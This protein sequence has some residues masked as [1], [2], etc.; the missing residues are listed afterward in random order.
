[1]IPSVQ[2]TLPDIPPLPVEELV[3]GERQ[4]VDEMIRTLEKQVAGD[5][6]V[7]G[8]AVR[9]AHPK[10]HGL[11]NATFI[12]DETCPV[13]LRHGLFC[14]PRAFPA[15]IRYSN[16][17]PTP[18]HDLLS[19]VRGM[20]I[21]LSGAKTSFL[22][23]EHHDFLLATGEAFFGRDAVD[24]VS[25]VPVAKSAIKVMW[26]F[27]RRLRRWHGGLQLL[28]G[29]KVP[30][31]PLAQ[32]YFSQTPY[33]LGPHCVKYHVRPSHSRSS[34]G[35]PLY[36][37]PIL[38][39]LYSWLLLLVS[40]LQVLI[41]LIVRPRVDIVGSMPGYDAMRG[42]LARDLMATHVK[43]DFLVEKWPDLSK[44]PAWAIEDPTWRWSAPWVKVATIDV[45]Q[46]TDIASRDG[47]AERMS[48][49]PWRVTAKHQ[50]LGSINRARY[51]IYTGMARYRNDLNKTGAAA[52]SVAPRARDRAVDDDE[53]ARG[54]R[55]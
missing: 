48:F 42:S 10:N 15:Q 23:D 54:V 26:Y 35:D 34:K 8:F 51:R 21:K 37:K 46:Q 28:N 11:V 43:L 32:E 4:A 24:F 5:A 2:P 1:M 7:S 30:P 38:R 47:V 49:T 36:L 14:T 25:F 16:G 20:A 13:D 29:R 6:R 52:S 41:N 33:R 44:L 39:N 55:D 18:A 22:G 27:F 53:T 9:D 19:D 12:V 3:P 17:A 31:S 40:Q 45:D 50:P